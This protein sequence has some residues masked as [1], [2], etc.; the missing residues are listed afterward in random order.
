MAVSNPNPNEGLVNIM[1]K[2]SDAY[3]AL[4]DKRRAEAFS[5]AALSIK[6]QHYP[7][8]SGKQAMSLPGVGK[9]SAEI[10][11]EYLSTGS[12]ARL[13]QLQLQL[14][15][16]NVTA[17]PGSVAAPSQSIDPQ[18]QQVLSLF[19]SVHGIGPVSAN[20]F[21]DEGYR[22]L[23]Q[24]YLHSN[25]NDSQ[26]LAIYWNQQLSQRIPRQEI[27]QI[28]ELF[29][30][31]FDVYGM[32]WNITGSYRRGA[33]TSGDIDV[34]IQEQNGLNMAGVLYLLGDKII[35]KFSEGPTKFMGIFKMSDQFNAHQIDI[36]LV[37]REAY[38]AALMYF[39]GSKQFNILMRTQAQA[40]QLSLNEYGLTSN[41]MGQPDP[42][43]HSEEEIFHILGV[44]YL[45]PTERNEEMVTLPLL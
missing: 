24:L 16:G 27:D 18:K 17:L 20:K 33:A 9:S 36:R 7:I 6:Q 38:P 26:R 15:G 19:Q 29:H 22:T 2:L 40:K 3:L 42:V 32:T 35:G 34:L 39:T 43:V 31:R 8:T 30:Q 41:I 28:E 25:L 5:K 14:S 23:E 37:S 21:Y 4:H 11:D 1:Q 10:I 12:V 13:A 45:P 44:K